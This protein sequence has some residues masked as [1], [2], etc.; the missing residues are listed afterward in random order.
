MKTR[1]LGSRGP[2]VSAIGL[3]CMTMSG[4]YGDRPDEAEPLATLDRALELGINFWDTADVYGPWH[5]EDL[6]GRSLKGRRD[7]VFLATKFGITAKGVNGSPD[8]VAQACDASLKRLNIET[9]D[10]YYLHRAERGRPIEETVGAMA[11][12]VKAGKVRH[13]GLS[14]VAPETLERACKVHPIAAV[15]SEY[16]LWTRDPEAGILEACERLG[17]G[18]VPYSPLGRG[19]LTGEIRSPDD[20]DES[21][22]R[23]GNP[24][25]QGAAFAKNLALVDKVRELADAKGVT[26]SQLALAWVMARSPHIVPIP[27][28]RRRKY[29]E[30]NAGAVDVSFTNTEL[31]EIDRSFPADLDAG[32]R[33]ADAMMGA[34]NG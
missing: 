26:P 16:S 30:D 31:A 1:K 27:G 28:T 32:Q 20:F 21:D 33:Y 2:E 19:F 17:V 22:W 9:I 10:L 25:F 8:Y 13:L 7:K 3:G 29:L 18:F 34:L 14:E 11:E 6:I 23:R 5:N 15:Q 4:V 12:L 24:R